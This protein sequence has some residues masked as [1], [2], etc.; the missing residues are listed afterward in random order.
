MSHLWRTEVTLLCY[1]G[2]SRETAQDASCATGDRVLPLWDLT[3][4]SSRIKLQLSASCHGCCITRPFPLPWEGGEDGEAHG[5]LFP[6]R[7]AVTH[8]RGQAQHLLHQLLRLSGLLQKQL[9]D[10]RQ[11][12]QLNLRADKQTLG[13]GRQTA[14]ALFVQERPSFSLTRCRDV[15]PTCLSRDQTHGDRLSGD[16]KRQGT[17]RG[18]QP[19]LQPVSSRLPHP[20]PVRATG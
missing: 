3:V 11:Q 18:S 16:D 5:R 6:H 12:L 15:T 10:G 20:Q 8:L 17:L 1:T 7:G 13:R 9:H 2:L 4:S 19:G 14:R